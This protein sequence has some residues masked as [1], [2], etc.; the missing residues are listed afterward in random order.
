ML[1]RAARNT[2]STGVAK[3]GQ[4]KLLRVPWFV[5]DVIALD[6]RR[7]RRYTGRPP[8]QFG[9]G[10][11][12]M[13]KLWLLLPAGVALGALFIR[14]PVV[15]QT[16]DGFGTPRPS[17][18]PATASAL[19]AGVEPAAAA[20]PFPL[21]QAAGSWL[22]CAAHY[23]GPEGMDLAIQTVNEL[24][25]KHRYQA[26]ILN[27]GEEERRK[28]DAEWE[29]Y[30]KRMHGAPVR[31]RIIRI[32]D[33]FAVLIGGF[34]DF[35]AATAALPKVRSLPLP[36]LSTKS[37]ASPFAEMF[38]TVPTEGKA[39]KV[40]TAKV[41]PYSQALVVRNPAIPGNANRPKFDPFLIKLNQDEEFNLL[42]N[43]KPYTLMV[44]EYGGARTVQSLVGGGGSGPSLL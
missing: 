20:N 43:P 22:I 26:Y 44:K 6:R 7:D 2:P 14:N 3:A 1:D 35:Q 40:M 10:G 33:E 39:P 18:A 37:G 32:E 25:T 9:T 24:R 12:A 11:R 30:K 31:R 28:Q 27:R 42:K 13:R 41:N 36:G 29:E 16:G 23:P 8:T 17:P 15:G 38:Y 4:G 34:K 21:T 5:Q 19:P